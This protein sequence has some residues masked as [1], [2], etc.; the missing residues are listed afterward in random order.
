MRLSPILRGQEVF[1]GGHSLD[2]PEVL[3]PSPVLG[4]VEVPEGPSMLEKM[5]DN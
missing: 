5:L 1:Y 4:D 2:A 3:I